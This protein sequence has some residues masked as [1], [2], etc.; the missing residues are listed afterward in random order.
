MFVGYMV[1]V[2]VSWRML[3]VL[4]LLREITGRSTLYSCLIPSFSVVFLPHLSLCRKLAHA[5]AIH[6]KLK[7]FSFTV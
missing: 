5:N 6:F 4:L 3:S 7:R 2:Y 1:T